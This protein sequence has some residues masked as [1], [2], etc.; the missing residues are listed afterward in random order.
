M[1][2]GLRIWIEVIESNVGC[3]TFSPLGTRLDTLLYPI[4]AEDLRVR[5][6]NGQRLAR[7]LI[8][9]RAISPTGRLGRFAAIN[10]EK[11][12]LCERGR[13]LHPLFAAG[14]VQN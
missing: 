11:V 2:N 1:F 4:A 3:I 7:S 8:R 9:E 13:W 14:R 6:F 12:K 10:A 5:L